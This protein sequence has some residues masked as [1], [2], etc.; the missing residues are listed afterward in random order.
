MAIADDAGCDWPARARMAVLRLAGEASGD[1]NDGLLLLAKLRDLFAPTEMLSSEEI[2]RALRGDSELPFREYRRGQG[3][4]PFVLSRMLK[5]YGVKPDR[6]R[7]S[8][9]TVRGYHRRQ[10]EAVWDRYLADDGSEEK[11][12]SPASPPKSVKSV[13]SSNSL[14]QAASRVTDL[15]GLD[16]L[17]ESPSRGKTS[18]GAEVD[19]LT[20]VTDLHV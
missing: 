16:G 11:N 4:S 17:A 1:E 5:P 10:L 18:E 13:R 9:T 14:P 8:Q 2:C 12:A 20:D 15:D 3:I 6:L 7:I 19:G